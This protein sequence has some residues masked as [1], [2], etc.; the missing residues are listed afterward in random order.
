MADFEKVCNQW[1]RFI[2]GDVVIHNG[3]RA[4]VVTAARNKIPAGKIPIRYE[5]SP[6]QG[7]ENYLIVF[8]DDIDL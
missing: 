7:E 3:R 8:V 2:K 1:G 4:Q 5:D 6:F